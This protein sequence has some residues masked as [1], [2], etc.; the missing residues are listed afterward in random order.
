MKREG[1]H[2]LG[3]VSTVVKSLAFSRTWKASV[4]AASSAGGDPCE[5]TLKKYRSQ[6]MQVL[7]GHVKECE[8]YSK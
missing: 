5:M 6:I 4:A 2:S 3:E 7:F 1:G 8:F